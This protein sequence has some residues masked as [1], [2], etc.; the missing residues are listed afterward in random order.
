M[1]TG[2]NSKMTNQVANEM[3]EQKRERLAQLLRE[4]TQQPKRFPLSFAQQRL[5]F[6]DELEGGNTIAYS[7]PV[8]LRLQGGLDKQRLERCFN[9][10]IRRHESL[11]TTF[12]INRATGETEQ[13]IHHSVALQLEVIDLSN[14]PADQRLK[15]ARALANQEALRPFNLSTG[16]LMRASLLTLA[17]DDHVLL[18]TIHHIVSD[19]WS[20]G[21]LIKELIALYEAY[22]RGEESPLSELPIQ[23]ADFAHWQRNRMQGE[24]LDRQLAYWRAQLSGHLPVIELP[25]RGPRPSRHSINGAV[26]VWGLPRDITEGVKHLGQEAGATLF[27]TLLAAFK[28]L[29]SRYTS[30]HDIL[31]GTPIANRNRAELEP[32][33]GLF[34]NTLV[35]RTDLSADPSFKQLMA[36]VKEAALGAYANQDV[37]FE[38][39]V[40]EL[41]PERD[42]ARTPFFQVM[43]VMQNAP[44]P[45]L[46]MGNVTMS[47]LV[48][49]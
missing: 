37:P 31:V 13:V 2:G 44:M 18:L 1:R 14:A 34:I 41:Q 24:V 39:L 16:P 30:Q 45:T 10:I 32:L 4:K 26:R 49:E 28:V 8:V 22:S 38:R 48:I 15:Q 33:I 43:F 42:L 40:E 7:I 29:L 3:P 20:V 6:L 46:R 19:G 23:Y 12:E 21:V 36:R 35:L 17:P 9:E 25:T 27:M 5:W 11:R 47:S